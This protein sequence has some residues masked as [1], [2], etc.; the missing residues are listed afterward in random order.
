MIGG[1]AQDTLDDTQL[2]STVYNF[3]ESRSDHSILKAAMFDA[4]PVQKAM[5]SLVGMKNSVVSTFKSQ[6]TRP[7]VSRPNPRA[8]GNRGPRT[9]NLSAR[10]P[11]DLDRMDPEAFVDNIDGMASAAFSNVTREVR[12]WRSLPFSFRL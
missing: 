3:L 5:E 12:I 7:K 1:G 10:E 4:P 9:R 8:L 11:P 2:Y 6:T